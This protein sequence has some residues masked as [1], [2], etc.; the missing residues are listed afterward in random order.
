MN[1]LAA[2]YV[3]P[4]PSKIN[5]TTFSTE[6]LS[7]L[8]GNILR[9]MFSLLCGPFCRPDDMRPRSHDSDGHSARLE[10]LLSNLAESLFLGPSFVCLGLSFPLCVRPFVGPSFVRLGL[11][12]PLCV[13]PFV[14]PGL[15]LGQSRL[16]F[17]PSA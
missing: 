17:D 9:N 12:F 16:G 2:S 11:S 5:C 15:L 7:V 4:Y 3:T 1:V 10:G 8:I 14:G 6:A 13:R